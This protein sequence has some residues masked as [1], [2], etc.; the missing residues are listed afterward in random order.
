[1]LR[2]THNLLQAVKFYYAERTYYPRYVKCVVVS[3][4]EADFLRRINPRIDTAI[5]PIGADAPE[6]FPA[7][8]ARRPAGDIV[9]SGQMSNPSTRD[10]IAWFAARIW[11][12]VRRQLPECRFW[13]VGR[14]PDPAIQALS[15][16]DPS[17]VV[18]GFVEDMRA[19][20]R[21]KLAYVCPLRHG[22]GIKTRLL[23]AMANGLPVV[24]TSIG[25]EGIDLIPG[26]HALVADTPEAFSEATVALLR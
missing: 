21:D 26:R 22:A 5:V 16:Q 10:G 6:E 18:T 19:T 7:E 24:T 9:F 12:S 14:A 11:P 13:L 20:L 25:A 17:I 2:K 23:E 8:A 1:M 3:Q 4:P 15:R